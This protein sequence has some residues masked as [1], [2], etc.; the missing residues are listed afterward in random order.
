MFTVSLIF[1]FLQIYIFHD[2]RDTAFYLLQDLA[3]VPLQVIIVTI[4][5]DQIVKYKEQ[6]DNFKKISVVIG[7][8][9]TET[10][11]NA[12]RNLSAFNLN[13]HEICKNL[14]IGDNWTDKDYNN[15][16]K[17]FKELNITIDSKASD[18]KLL[19]E[20]IFSN[21]QNILTMFEN[22]TLLEHNNFTD[23]LWSLYHIYDELNFRDNLYDL[24]EEDFL[25]L[26]IDIKRCYQLMVVEWLNY[27][28]HLKT[29]YPF[30]YS[31][32]VRKNPFSD[33]ALAKSKLFVE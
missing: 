13:F 8:F 21:R 12:I 5:I 26:S 2:Q 31:L 16:I 24:E 30:L 20:F 1:Y 17:E 29:E 11:V 7:A 6:Q 27:M 33:K 9:F 19:K 28:S 23:M 3:F 4:L 25:H 15:A 22:K 10:G 32:A 18:L 14:S